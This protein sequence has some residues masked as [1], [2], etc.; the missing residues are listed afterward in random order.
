M[1]SERRENYGNP[2]GSI[3]NEQ[4][5]MIIVVPLFFGLLAFFVYTVGNSLQ[6]TRIA[7]TQADIQT[8]LL[9]K[10][11]SSQELLQYLQ[12]D[13]GQRFFQPGEAPPEPR[14][15][16]SRIL[17]SITAGTIMTFLGIGFVLMSR[18]IDEGMLV[19]GVFFLAIGLG[20]LVSSA[21]AF[22]LSKSWGLFDGDKAE[23][24]N[25]N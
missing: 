5:V 22:H 20:F 8:T 9:N 19:P 2:G 16:Y 17:R 14:S 11:G 12:T 18:L 23:P 4:I 15:P 6:R 7:R 10:F 13:A 24:A 1:N 25:Q 3:V 21:I